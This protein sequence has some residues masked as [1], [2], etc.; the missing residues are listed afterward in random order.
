MERL[1][2]CP[3]RTSSNAEI[4]RRA[5]KVRHW[6]LRQDRANEIINF[7][8][9]KVIQ[10]NMTILILYYVLKDSSTTQFWRNSGR[11]DAPLPVLQHI[12]M[13]F[14]LHCNLLR[15][16]STAGKLQ[17][18][19]GPPIVTMQKQSVCQSYSVFF[20][21]IWKLMAG[22][23]AAGWRN[24]IRYGYRPGGVLSYYYHF[25][26]QSSQTILSDLSVL[27]SWFYTLLLEFSSFQCC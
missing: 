27:F 2:R 14:F 5:P 21:L 12:S 25:T 13:A 10:C 19:H 16:I 8:D 23:H 20:S 22:F 9:F 24:P 6:E 26:L 18:G 1:G 7:Q 17:R 3:T 15:P 11:T 4:H